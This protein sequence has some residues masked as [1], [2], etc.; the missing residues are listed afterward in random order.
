MRAPGIAAEYQVDGVEC[1]RLAP[2][3]ALL[4]DRSIARR[5]EIEWQALRSPPWRNN[6]AGWRLL[7]HQ[8]TLFTENAAS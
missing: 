1:M 4:R 7:F 2:G 8:G 5:Q 6:A 3:L